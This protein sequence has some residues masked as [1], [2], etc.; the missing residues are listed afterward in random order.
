M[1]PDVAADSELVERIVASTG[2]TRPEATRVIEDVIAFHTEPVEEFVR[3]RHAHLKTYGGKNPEIFAR[4]ADELA[5][6]VVAAPRLTDRQL[7]RIV[8]G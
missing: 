6:R 3:R 7:R 5:A 1:I 8:Y 2:L 4:I